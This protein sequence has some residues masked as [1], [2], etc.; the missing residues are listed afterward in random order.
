[1]RIGIFNGDVGRRN[2]DGYVA[3]AGTAHEQGF[4]S[5]WVPQ[6]FSHDALTLLADHR[7]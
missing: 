5:Y 3:A 4:A 1:M 6:V 7:A 2:V